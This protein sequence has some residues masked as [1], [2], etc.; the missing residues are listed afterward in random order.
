MMPFDR[1]GS[2]RFSN[3]PRVTQLRAGRAES[4]HRQPL[5]IS[6][7]W[8]C[9]QPRTG[10]D[11]VGLNLGCPGS[12]PGGSLLGLAPGPCLAE[13]PAEPPRFPRPFSQTQCVLGH[14]HL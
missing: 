7:T 9:S 5:L 14:G 4:R 8:A 11:E 10:R 3:L 13:L 2:E 12:F 6:T 1:R